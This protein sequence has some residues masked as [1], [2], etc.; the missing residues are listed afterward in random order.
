[1]P[2]EHGQGLFHNRLHRL[3]RIGLRKVEKHT[4]DLV[5]QGSGTLVCSH[6]IL[7]CRLVILGDDGVYF[8]GLTVY[9][10]FDGLHVILF[11]NLVERRDA[12]RGVPLRK[13]RIRPVA[14]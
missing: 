8:C 7:K 14:G 10:G 11:M 5:K 1:M 4:G 3:G 13:E 9:T 12:V 6:G 2:G